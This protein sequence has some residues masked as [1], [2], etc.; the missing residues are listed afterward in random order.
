MCSSRYPGL[1]CLV[2]MMMM[3]MN[4]ETQKQGAGCSEESV[5]LLIIDMVHA[6]PREFGIPLRGYAPEG[7]EVTKWRRGQPHVHVIISS[8]DWIALPGSY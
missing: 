1:A 3:M 7:E 6:D 8:L 2:A 5:L 4:T